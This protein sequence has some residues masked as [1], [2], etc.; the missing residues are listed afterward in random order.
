[1]TTA[2]AL[3]EKQEKI[4]Q[5]VKANGVPLPGARGLYYDARSCCWIVTEVALAS[6]TDFYHAFLKFV[7]KHYNG[8]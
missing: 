6:D 3:I 2:L 8:N 4:I 7:E 1:M 5:S